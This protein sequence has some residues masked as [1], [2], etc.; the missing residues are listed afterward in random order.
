MV[1]SSKNN[2]NTDSLLLKIGIIAYCLGNDAENEN[3]LT[4]FYL[5]MLIQL[6][7]TLFNLFIYYSC[8]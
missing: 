7:L 2:P 3:G 4:G 1:N 6:L 5:L 8:L